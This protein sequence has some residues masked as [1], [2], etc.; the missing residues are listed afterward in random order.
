MSWSAPGSSLERLSDPFFVPTQAYV[1]AATKGNGRLREWLG[2]V[3]THMSNLER[4]E[5]YSQSPVSF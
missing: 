4:D 5:S 2:F 3:V 1:G